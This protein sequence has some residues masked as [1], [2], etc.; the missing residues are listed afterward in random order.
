MTP[1]ELASAAIIEALREQGDLMDDCGAPEWAQVDGAFRVEPLARAVL[2][3]IREP[4]EAMID[5]AR[6]AKFPVY[7]DGKDH[8]T[9]P[10]WQA[11]VDAALAEGADGL[12]SER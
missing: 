3:A 11:M 8:S 7:R 6:N 10:R 4:S 2:A 9:V 12:L 1:L 5:A